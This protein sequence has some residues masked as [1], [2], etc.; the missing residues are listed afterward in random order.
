M[1]FQ[2]L[3]DTIQSR[4]DNIL[5]LNR[6]HGTCQFPLVNRLIPRTHDNHLIQG[7]LRFL[8]HHVNRILTRVSDFTILHSHER[9]QQGKL[10]HRR[11]IQDIPS[12]HVRHRSERQTLH[13][14][15]HT[16]KRKFLLVRYP[17]HDTDTFLLFIIRNFHLTLHH[18]NI[19][20]EIVDQIRPFKNS[21]QHILH[22]FTLHLD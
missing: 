20:P 4:H 8:H 9:K 12:L 17:T 7:Y 11:Q 16:R 18:D 15:C 10:F 5:R 21:L 14:H 3:V 13:Q 1:P 2:H 22:G 6:S 19:P